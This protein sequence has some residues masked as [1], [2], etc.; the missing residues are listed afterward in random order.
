MQ[1]VVWIT[2]Y[3]CR[4]GCSMSNQKP[5][6]ESLI[7]T[8]QPADGLFNTCLHKYTRE[9]KT[10]KTEDEPLRR[11]KPLK[12]RGLG[13]NII[14]NCVHPRLLCFSLCTFHILRTRE[15]K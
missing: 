11:K 12:G 15:Q 6:I 10:E 5:G 9:K 13:S 4:G 3:M 2:H 14:G 7:S 1:V 8:G